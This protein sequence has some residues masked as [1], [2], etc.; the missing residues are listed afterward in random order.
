MVSLTAPFDRHVARYDAWYERNPHAYSAELA[1]IRALLPHGAKGVEV[2]VGTGRFAAPL[3]IG[4]G[5][6]PSPE[7]A[8][9]AAERGVQVMAG[10]AENLPFPEESLDFVLMVNVVCFL[11]EPAAAFKEAWR[12]L[13]NRGSVLV[14]FIDRESSLGKSYEANKETSLF[15]RGATFRTPAEILSLLRSAGFSDF[16]FCQTL[17]RPLEE[18][19]KDE[20][21]LEGHGEGSFVVVRGRKSP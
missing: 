11:D 20:P 15:Y 6:E 10:V 19:D 2:G 3:G 13:K 21:V 7:M 16:V 17:F 8:K 9:V 12:V 18:L 14:G 5:V 1:A 4:V